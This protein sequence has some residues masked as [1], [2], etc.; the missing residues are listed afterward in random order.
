MNFQPKSF[1]LILFAIL[2]CLSTSHPWNDWHNVTFSHISPFPTPLPVGT[3]YYVSRYNPGNATFAAS[4][5]AQYQWQIHSNNGILQ[6]NIYCGPKSYMTV[7]PNN[8]NNI[9]C[10]RDMS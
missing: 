6:C 1:S 4:R 2:I 5:K 10:K 3:G 8:P 9:V 7:D